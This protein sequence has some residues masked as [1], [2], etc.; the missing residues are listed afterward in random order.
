MKSVTWLLLFALKL[1]PLA[2]GIKFPTPLPTDTQSPTSKPPWPT[3]GLQLKQRDTVTTDRMPY[4]GIL[5]D[6]K[7]GGW[8]DTTVFGVYQF[9]QAYLPST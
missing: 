9:Q 7:R 1:S 5:S 2:H 6:P 8:F 3:A 4:A